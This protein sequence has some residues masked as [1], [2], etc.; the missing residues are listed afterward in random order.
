MTNT[1]LKSLIPAKREASEE[2]AKHGDDATNK[3]LDKES[4]P[5]SIQMI[6]VQSFSHVTTV[7]P[8]G[9]VLYISLGP[10]KELILLSPDMME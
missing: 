5:S 4:V 2:V 1:V 8:P 9:P 7:M 6:A 3:I 10:C